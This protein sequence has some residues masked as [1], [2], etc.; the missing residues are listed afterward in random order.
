MAILQLE[1]NIEL[2]LA[3]T[4][5]RRRKLLS[6]VG[7][8]FGI[9]SP[10]IDESVRDNELPHDLVTRLSLAKATEVAD[11]HNTAWVLAA[12]TVVCL[13]TQILGKPASKD[14]AREMLYALSGRSHDVLG[15]IALVNQEQGVV[16]TRL[17][18]TQVTFSHLMSEYIECYVSS[19][20]CMDKAGAYA[21]QG[22]PQLFVTDM[23]GSYTNVVGLDMAAVMA[24]LLRFSLVASMECL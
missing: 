14:E 16:T 5:P 2:L 7:L 22:F 11:R 24:L 6:R 8:Q 15:G 17:S 18:R 23:H 20:E 13:G 19:G 21:I 4:S 10:N 1:Q 9:E 3:S 12:D